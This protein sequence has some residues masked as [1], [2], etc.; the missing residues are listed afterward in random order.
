MPDLDNNIQL[1]QQKLLTK[2]K[3]NKFITSTVIVSLSFW[4]LGVY[5]FI[6][7]FSNNGMEGLG[8]AII[9]AFIAIFLIFLHSIQFIWFAF[10]RKNRKRS[11]LPFLSAFIKVLILLIFI[12]A[13]FIALPFV[14]FSLGR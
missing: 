7:S 5:F 2:M 4:I 9:S 1:K 11:K 13:S 12:I 14:L 8:P 6:A 10:L 3:Y